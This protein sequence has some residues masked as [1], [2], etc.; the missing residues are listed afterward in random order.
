MFIQIIPICDES[1]N[2]TPQNVLDD[3]I[4]KETN[5]NVKILNNDKIIKASKTYFKEFMKQRFSA[6]IMSY[7]HKINE[8]TWLDDTVYFKQLKIYRTAFKEHKIQ[9]LDDNLSEHIYNDKK[10]YSLTIQ[11]IDK[12]GEITTNI[13][14]GSCEIFNY[15]IN[16]YVY[17]YKNKFDRDNAYK[18]LIK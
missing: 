5:T 9:V 6:K 13:C 14:I 2:I 16:G 4:L 8:W 17:Y 15:I 1:V 10:W 12:T 11:T 18:Y 7:N 3:E